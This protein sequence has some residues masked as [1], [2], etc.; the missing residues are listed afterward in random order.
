MKKFITSCQNLIIHNSEDA[1]DVNEDIFTNINSRYY[2]L[3]SINKLKTDLSSLGILH[4]NL[5]SIYKYHDDLELI[6]S[7]IKTKFQIIGITEHKI[8]DTIPIANINLAGYHDFIYNPTQTTHGGTG[9]Y[10]KDSLV[11]KLRNDLLLIP[12]NPGD[13]ESTFIEI[14]IPN[15]RNLVLGC[16]YRHPSS[17]IRIKDFT[18]KYLEPLLNSISGENKICAL[19]GDFNIDLLKVETHEDINSYYNCLS[20]NFFAPYILQPTRPVSKSLIDNI[21][22]NTVEYSSFSGN[23]TIQLA[24]HFFQFLILQGFFYDTQRKKVNIKERNFKNFNEREF[25]E[26]LQNLDICSILN[27]NE[28]NPNKSI[29]SLYSNLTYLLDEMAPYKKLNNYELKLKSKP[30]IN[31]EVQFLMWERDKIFKKFRNST[32]D[33]AKLQLYSKYKQMRNNLT[34]LKRNN[35]K[36]YYENYFKKYAKKSAAIWK[37]IR[38]LITL[39]ASKKSDISILESNGKTITDPTEIVKCFNNY[40]VNVGPNVEN[41]IPTS[42][43]PY[44]EYLKE[45]NV[46]NSFYLRPVHTYEIA[47]IIDSLDL[48]KTP[49]PN[50]ISIYILKVCK[51]FIS[52]GLEKI[53]NL[54]FKTG[55][56]PNLCKVAKVIPIFK[57]EDPLSCKNYRPISLLPIFSKIFEKV[58]YTRMYQYIEQNHLLYDKQ[59][60]F[61]SKHSTSHA[62]ISLTESIKS[63]LDNKEIVSGIF[64]D[65]AKA[66]DTVNH[67]ILCY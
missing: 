10:V 51:E 21:F 59:F 41:K 9:F 56:F 33:D 25:V 40:F 14:I 4:T 66:F 20:S 58:I 29:E 7:L 27:I 28:N 8:R 22:L 37:G 63:C 53:L 35:K 24:D 18:D 36:N 47:D 2:D 6:L 60:G 52:N 26:V 57:K 39:K 50:S 46:N 67:S 42:N 64:I 19:M 3:F 61:R 12:P 62:L 23:L 15:K 13:F 45:V 17:I 54:S 38:S 30:W 16:I 32:D 5:A 11:Y 34:T 49:G 31:E 43:I 44:T 1:T 48:K 55:I 65:L